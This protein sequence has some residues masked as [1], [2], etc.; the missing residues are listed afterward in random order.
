LPAIN[1]EDAASATVL[2][3]DR[4]TPGAI[5]DIVDDHPVSMAE[6]VTTIAEYTGSSAPRRVP[7]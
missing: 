7:A 6:F 1:I 5:Y 2:A 3:L 4:A